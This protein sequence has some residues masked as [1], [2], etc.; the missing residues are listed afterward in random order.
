[1]KSQGNEDARGPRL[2]GDGPTPPDARG[3][4]AHDAKRQA[5]V[6]RSLM[7][8][9]ACWTVVI[10]SASSSGISISNSSSRAM[11]SSTVWSSESAPRSSTNEASFVTCFLLDAQLLGNDGFDL[12]LNCAH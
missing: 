1:M 9:M 8:S 12:L 3:R 2:S 4:L 6:R 10:F 5:F 7:Y 11:T